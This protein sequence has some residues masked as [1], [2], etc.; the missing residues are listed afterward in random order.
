MLNLMITSLIP[1]TWYA[2]AESC[3][4]KWHIDTI[5]FRLVVYTEN[6]Q[7]FLFITIIS[8]KRVGYVDVELHA[9]DTP[10]IVTPVS[11]WTKRFPVQISVCNWLFWLTFLLM[12]PNP[13][14][15]QD[16]WIPEFRFKFDIL[17]TVYHNNVTNLIHFNFHKHF[18]VS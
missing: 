1:P 13:T 10:G 9:F 3:I 8:L 6:I 14:K 2:A 4:V 7:L 16:G 15:S 12:F 5:T 18:I 17:L 11:Y